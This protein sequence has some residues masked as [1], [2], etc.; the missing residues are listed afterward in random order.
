MSHLDDQRFFNARSLYTVEAHAAGPHAL[1]EPQPR[2]DGR[3][4]MGGVRVGPVQPGA[5]YPWPDRE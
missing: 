1:S 4:V 5:P 3:Y 2:G